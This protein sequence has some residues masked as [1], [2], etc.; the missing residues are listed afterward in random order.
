MYPFRRTFL[1]V[2]FSLSGNLFTIQEIKI[3]VQCE[4]NE[5]ITSLRCTFVEVFLGCAFC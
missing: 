3:H 4:M 2:R 1:D 5:N